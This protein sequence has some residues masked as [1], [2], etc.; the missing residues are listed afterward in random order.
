MNKD[1]FLI[2]YENEIHQ[3]MQRNAGVYTRI[4]TKMIR[5][6]KQYH[7]DVAMLCDALFQKEDIAAFSVATTLWKHFSCS[8]ER[9]YLPL[10]EQWA[11][12]YIDS[13]YTCDQFCY[14]VLN[15]AIEAFPCFYPIVLTWKQY[16]KVYV[17][18]AIAVSL[19]HSSTEICV[20]QPCAYVYEACEVLKEEMHPHIQKGMGWLLKYAYLRYPKEV[21]A[22]IIQHIE[23]LSSTTFSYA[24]EKMSKETREELRKMR[25]LRGS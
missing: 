20:R 3:Y 18:R 25:K 15:P 12:C 13:W 21:V 10:I 11:L 24:L 17:H 14:R 9:T 16:D 2:I 7:L 23:Q 4:A 1:D 8:Q 5:I 22:Y 6:I 19:L